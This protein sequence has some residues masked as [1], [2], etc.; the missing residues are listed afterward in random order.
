MTAADEDLVSIFTEKVVRVWLC[1]TPEGSVEE[2]SAH[3]L[4][5]E[6]EWLQHERNEQGWE[7]FLD[8]EW[9]T[10]TVSGWVETVP[11][12]GLINGIAPEQ[13]FLL[14]IANAAYTT[15]HLQEGTETDFEFDSEVVRILDQPRKVSADAWQSW[16]DEE[17]QAREH[18]VKLREEVRWRQRSDV[19]HM[20]LCYDA[21]FSGHYVDEMSIPTGV[22][23]SLVSLVGADP[24]TGKPKAFLEEHSWRQTS[25]ASGES[26]EGSREQALQ[27]CIDV[28]VNALPGLTAERIRLLPVVRNFW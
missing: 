23:C 19:A 12:W 8:M 10:A 11:Y 27:R 25:L 6:P 14:E 4:G 21:F 3:A 24:D 20:F 7:S 22:R 18:A 15:Y 5:E 1:F 17:M 16:C 13:P 26:A 2:V 28:A 9:R